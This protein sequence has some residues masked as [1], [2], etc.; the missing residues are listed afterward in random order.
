MFLYYY[1]NFQIFMEIIIYLLHILFPYFME[2]TFF[3]IIN[4]FIT[5]NLN[6]IIINL[7]FITI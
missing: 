1:F 6:F 2:A 4:I 5:K 7:L 3:F